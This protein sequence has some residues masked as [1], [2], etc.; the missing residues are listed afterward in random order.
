MH[1]FP[2]TM[3]DY[4]LAN[5]SLGVSTLVVS[6]FATL[7]SAKAITFIL[8]YYYG[9][10]AFLYHIAFVLTTVS[11]GYFVFLKLMYFR[12]AYTIS[13]VMAAIYGP[14]ARV[15]TTLIMTVFFLLMMVGQLQEF[16][17]NGCILRLIFP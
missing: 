8:P 7:M 14:F 6:L 10:I 2:K 9:I 17:K 3:R 1:G 11:L 4:A 16:G 15:A 13:D 12:D 5:R